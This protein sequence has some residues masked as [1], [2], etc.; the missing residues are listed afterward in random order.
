MT[1]AAGK[2]SQARGDFGEEV[3]RH[4]LQELGVRMIEK[5]NTPFTVIRRMGRIVGAFPVEK[6]SGDFIGIG[7]AGK[8]VLVEV[9]YREDCLSISDFGKHQIAALEENSQLGGISLVV[10]VQRHV[11]SIYYWPMMELKKG[12]PLKPGEKFGLQLSINF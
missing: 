9:K 5:V 12:A 7:A 2:L 10:W 1:R 8:K 4:A 6:V 3:A 11:C